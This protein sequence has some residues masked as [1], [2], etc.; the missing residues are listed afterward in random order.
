MASAVVNVGSWGQWQIIV[1]EIGVNWGSNSSVVRVRGIMYNKGTSRSFNNNG[2]AVSVGGTN[3]W[4][5]RS[6][7]NINAG[8]SQTVID[9]QF[10]VGHDANGDAYVNY[11]IGLG[12]TGTGTFGN[13]GNVSV[14]AWLTHIQ[15]STVPP[16][17]TA[18]VAFDFTQTS[19]TVQF[20]YQGDGNSPILGWELH[21]GHT[22]AGGQAS[23]A[24]SGTTYLSGLWTAT[25]YYFWARGRNANGWGPFSGPSGPFYTYAGGQV[26]KGNNWHAAIPYVNVNGTWRLAKP[27]VKVAGVW[28]RADI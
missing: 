24:S 15:Q 25:P 13:G 12:P 8:G 11:S 23:A 20:H 14:G 4:S 18:P 9:V 5:G 16:A 21:W 6:P 28:K 10:T 19:M 17:P 26:K 22:P 7:F 2:V 1:E 3:G 27:W